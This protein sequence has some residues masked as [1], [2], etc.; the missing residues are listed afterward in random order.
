MT[1]SLVLALAVGSIV[2]TGAV[3]AIAL[4]L[5]GPRRGA[6]KR[7]RAE[8]RTSALAPAPPAPPAPPA[9]GPAPAASAAPPDQPGR[10]PAVTATMSTAAPPPIFEFD[11]RRSKLRF[12]DVAGLDQAIEE[13]REVA[14]H[15]SDPARFDAVGAECPRGIMLYGPPGCGKTL[16]ARALAGET[17]V[18]FYSISGASFVEQ[19]VGVGASRVRQLFVGAK[20]HAPCIVFLD[21]IDAMGRSRNDGS[22]GNA[23][24]DHTLNQLLVELD[25]FDGASGVLVLGATNRLELLDP[26][27]LRPGRFDRRIS[28]DR[29]DRNGRE[30]I[31]ALHAERRPFSPR[32][33][34]AQVAAHTT[35]L[36]PS[37]LANIV[38]EAALLAARRHRSMIAPEDVEEASARQLSGAPGSQVI[39][40]DARWLLSVHES[41]HALLSQ[42]L[43]GV[44][45]PPRVSILPRG[46][47]VDR[48][49]WAASE[50]REV[51]T[52]RELIAR[53]MLLLGGRAAELN[54]FGEPSTQAE[55]DLGHAATMARQMVEKWAM[56]GRF[57][58]AA[59]AKAD[60]MTYVEGSA[61]GG[62]VRRLVAAAENAARTILTDNHGRLMHLA[63]VLAE[64]ETL[65]DQEVAHFAGQ[66]PGPRRFGP[67]RPEPAVRRPTSM[68]GRRAERQVQ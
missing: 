46:G 43:K 39:N 16:L 5:T 33:D 38:N 31:L 62:E 26:A 30:Q 22:G 52:K 34:W 10:D 9:W 45:P 54:I 21:E 17:G 27:L 20:K 56:T 15:L 6:A 13:L 51:L 32:V 65:S 48:S 24:F 8:R 37:E 25:G 2:V 1:Q 60:R 41:G 44:H 23:E 42:L 68:M 67:V 11:P 53:L 29:P 35:G 19:Y 28:V 7:A 47:G 49:V 18:P 14:E 36:A 57:E 50:A 66:T 12:D 58:L 3:T 61:G 59:S 4:L 64:R 55:D 63:N 40:E